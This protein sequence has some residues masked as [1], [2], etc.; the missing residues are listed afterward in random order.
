MWLTW[1]ETKR[2]QNIAKHGMDFAELSIEFFESATIYPAKRERSLAV[3]EWNGSIVIAV[4]FQP[5][6]SQALSIISMRP[7]SRKERSL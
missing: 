4:I 3:G 7:A 5:L 1:D 2:Q 6:G